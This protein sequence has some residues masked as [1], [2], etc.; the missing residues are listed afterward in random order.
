MPANIAPST[1]FM[2]APLRIGFDDSH[3]R[4]LYTAISNIYKFLRL[5]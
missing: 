4:L 2:T 5:I 1:A 3:F